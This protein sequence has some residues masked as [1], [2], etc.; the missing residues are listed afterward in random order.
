MGKNS[1]QVLPLLAAD[2]PAL[3]DQIRAADRD[4]I[5]AA[6]GMPI[7]AALWQL[8][9]GSRKAFKIVH[10]GLVLALFGDAQHSAGLG[11]PWL[12]STVHVDRYPREFLRVCKPAV[13]EML[14][15]HGCLLNYVDAR[16]LTAIRWLRWLGF[17]FGEAV[18]Y[19]H[20]GLPFLPFTM[21][22]E[23]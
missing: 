10:E 5:E 1:A 13:A 18:P 20:A 23:V 14:A 9:P 19:G 3:V 15:H 21:K 7:E 17:A 2:L 12:I 6:T 8:I 4:E 22:N 16:N 11:V